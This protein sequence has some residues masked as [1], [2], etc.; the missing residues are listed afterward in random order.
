MRPEVASEGGGL[1]RLN[2]VRKEY[3]KQTPRFLPLLFD[4]YEDRRP[5][6]KKAIERTL[7]SGWV[8]GLHP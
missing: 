4:E 3:I 5:E 2:S 8:A 6:L 1:L 7:T